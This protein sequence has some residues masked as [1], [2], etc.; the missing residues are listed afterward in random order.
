MRRN[1][2]PATDIL[3]T[4]GSQLTRQD[5]NQIKDYARIRERVQ[6]R[7]LAELSPVVDINNTS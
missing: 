3:A 4:R 6:R 2:R 1:Q 5:I 7:L